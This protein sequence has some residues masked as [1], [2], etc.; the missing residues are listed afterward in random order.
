MTV[1]VEQREHLTFCQSH[2]FLTNEGVWYHISIVL[3]VN[4]DIQFGLDYPLYRAMVSRVPYNLSTLGTRFLKDKRLCK[5]VLRDNSNK[6]V[7][8]VDEHFLEWQSL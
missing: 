5:N 1:S 6:Y 4:T 8:S 7:P 3:Y 2:R